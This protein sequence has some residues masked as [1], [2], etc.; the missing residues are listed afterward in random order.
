M[1]EQP[2]LIVREGQLLGQRWTVDAAEFVVGRG[3]DSNL[4]LPER[5]V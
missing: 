2:V 5:Q 4:V 3:S 1:D